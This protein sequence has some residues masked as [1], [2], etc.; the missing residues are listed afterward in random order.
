M[1]SALVHDYFTQL[2][3]AE[4]VAAQLF[5]LLPDA[6]L[7]AAV[8]LPDRIPA[9]LRRTRI[10]TSWMQKLPGLATNYRRYFLLY[11]LGIESLDLSNYDLVISSSSGYG[12]G[13]RARRDAVHVCYCHNPMRW[14]WSFAQYS[15]RERMSH[16]KRAVLSAVV[17][18]LRRWD[19]GASREPDHFVANSQTVAERILKT[20]G[21]HA[22]VIHP[23]IQVERFRPS[24]DREDYYLVLA[25]L[26]SYKR[27]DLAIE[28]CN[29]LGRELLI[30]GEGPDRQRLASLAGPAIHFAGRLSDRDVEYHAARCR[31]LIFPG[32]EDF[33]MAPLEVAAA[34]RPTVA[35]YGGGARETIEDGVTGIF[36]REQTAESLADALLRLE[37]TQWSSSILRMH[38]EKFSVEA[39]RTRFHSFLNRV[40]VTIAQP[41]EM[42]ST[43]VSPLQDYGWT[44]AEDVA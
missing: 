24:A 12:K 13:V 42:Q 28:A 8:A 15:E 34:G 2:G 40:G 6:D 36:F 25:R 17:G 30:I 39:F 7:F 43:V 19:L 23:P 44:V 11:P 5:D 20:Y 37:T 14:A 10:R 22:E 29:R 4:Q 41:D 21:R 18:A 26:V 9:G 16:A 1:K 33:G 31:A 35:Y 32:E 27:I 38:A 3:G